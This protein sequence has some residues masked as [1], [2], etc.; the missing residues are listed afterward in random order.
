MP[1]IDIDLRFE[2]RG[3]VSQLAVGPVSADF[4]FG[5]EYTFKNIVYLRGGYN[6]LKMFSIGAGVKLPKLNIDYSF[7]SFNSQDQL[8]NTHRVSFTITFEQAK[9]KRE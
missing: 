1:A 5:A 9:W 4:H 7:L 3:K 2:N 8:G 6:D